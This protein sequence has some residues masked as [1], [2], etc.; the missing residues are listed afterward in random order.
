MEESATAAGS[1]RIVHSEGRRRTRD[2]LE[3]YWQRW[4]PA[5][6]RGL[7]LA[8]HGLFE[9]SSRYLNLARHMTRAGW[10]CYAF[11]L[12]G[13]GLSPGARVHVRRFDEFLE[14]LAALRALL[15]ELHPDLAVIPVGHSH[16]GLVVLL[17]A[18]RRGRAGAGV[19]VSSPLLAFHPETRPSPALMLLARTLSVAWPS[20]RLPVR[21]DPEGL[22]HDQLVVEAYAKDPLIGRRA[23]SSWLFGA[24]AAMEEARA[25]AAALA[26]PAL[27]MAAGED[28]FV[29]SA[30]TARWCAAAPPEL[31]EHVR[32]NGLR[33]ELFN[34]PEKEQVF[35]RMDAW[36]SVR[37]TAAEGRGA[38][39]AGSVR[40]SE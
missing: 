7:L 32:W 10:G 27:V 30:V 38:R 31:V 36:L 17:D 26:V 22:C 21:I 9:H 37:M 3:L 40:A 29:D 16:G 20:L 28:R 11:D 23:S 24:L 12:R 4:L 18:L 25:G 33:H 13:H 39:S 5:T 35:A 19:V 2:D 14:D 6:P 34:E 1:G 8:V 15:A